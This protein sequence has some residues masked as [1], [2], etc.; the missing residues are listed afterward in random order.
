[1]LQALISCDSPWHDEVCDAGIMK[2]TD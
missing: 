2:L 1:M